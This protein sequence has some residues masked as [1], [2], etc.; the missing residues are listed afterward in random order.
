MEPGPGDGNRMWCMLQNNTKAAFIK[1]PNAD[2]D[3]VNLINGTV[4][5]Q[6]TVRNAR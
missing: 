5:L 1:A 4:L 6:L 3:T 2:T